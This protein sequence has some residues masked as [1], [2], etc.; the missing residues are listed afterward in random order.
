[1]GAFYGTQIR[2]GEITLEDVPKFWRKKTEK[3][4]KENPEE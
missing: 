1:M 4:L 3:W 2:S